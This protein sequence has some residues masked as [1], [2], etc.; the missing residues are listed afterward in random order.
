MDVSDND[1]PSR[2][3]QIQSLIVNPNSN[4]AATSSEP[5]ASSSTDGESRSRS[6]DIDASKLMCRKYMVGRCKKAR[7]CQYSHSMDHLPT[8]F[9]KDYIYSFCKYGSRCK[10]K[11]LNPKEENR[12]EVLRKRYGKKKQMTWHDAHDF[13]P[14]LPYIE[15]QPLPPNISSLEEMKSEPLCQHAIEGNCEDIET[16]MFLHGFICEHCNRPIIHPFDRIQGRTHKELCSKTSKLIKN[17]LK[18]I[19]ESEKEE[20]GICLDKVLNT[21]KKEEDRK[22]G[23]MPG[24]KHKFCLKC[25]RTWRTR[26]A[27]GSS[28]SQ[29][30]RRGCPQCRQKSYFVVPSQVWI[31]DDANKKAYI[32][33]YKKDL[34]MRPCKYHRHNGDC[35][36]KQNCFYSH[37][38]EVDGQGE[39]FTPRERRDL[40]ESDENPIADLDIDINIGA[41][42]HHRLQM[43]RE[44]LRELSVSG[45]LEGEAAGD[46]SGM[47][48][49]LSE[50]LINRGILEDDNSS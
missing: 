49:A 31:P 25:I 50:T 39:Q 47:F 28:V 26:P 7:K 40:A 17:F 16:C 4:L 35:P 38:C 37:E 18:L 42:I 41:D 21:E 36:F 5:R 19:K 45:Q 15:R 33:E 24:C 8:S 12:R 22:F 11:H 34:K 20:C 1:Y 6:T 46:L 2:S 44:S 9:C 43:I 13:E 32:E 48:D 29:E 3:S 30:N 10:K 23:L 14:G 27:E